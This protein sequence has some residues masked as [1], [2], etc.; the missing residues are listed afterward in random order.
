MDY[1]D[2]YI[3][4]KQ[5]YL[6]LK[7]HGGSK[8]KKIKKDRVVI[9]ISGH[10][11]GISPTITASVPDGINLIFTNHSTECLESNLEMENIIITHDY[12][13]LD[14]LFNTPCNV[15]ASL[16][17]IIGS[18][19]TIT[20]TSIEEYQDY[21]YYRYNSKSKFKDYFINFNNPLLITDDPNAIEIM[22]IGV[23][24]NNQYEDFY[25]V[26][27]DGKILLGLSSSNKYLISEK[28]REFIDLEE[29]KKPYSELNSLIDQLQPTIESHVQPTIESHLQPEVESHLPQKVES[30]IH[31]YVKDHVGLL[32]D[33]VH[34]DEKESPDI[35]NDSFHLRKNFYKSIIGNI[36]P[37]P[38][39][40]QI[41]LSTLL[42]KINLR[43]I[44]PESEY[45]LLI[46][47]MT[48]RK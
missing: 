46:F 13:F 36:L 26:N 25:K 38:P 30:N 15:N 20:S 8:S 47:V 23:F 45:D 7:Q 31:P 48:C 33:S 16:E 22:K 21:E 29:L 2:K 40:R 39:T 43:N 3:L 18:K 19:N 6:K 35:V 44:Y 11:S 32:T 1:F 5:K 10:G 27:K 4:Y 41:R 42:N 24:Q 34:Y 17:D 28:D 14:N 9:I 37:L 12:D